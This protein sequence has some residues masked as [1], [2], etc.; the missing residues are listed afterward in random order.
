M[1]LKKQ[2]IQIARQARE[3]CPI[4]AG[5]N[6]PQ[7]NQALEKMARALIKRQ[8]SIL[9]ENKQDMD[10]AQKAGH[11]KAFLDR[12]RLTAGTLKE[13]AQGLQE[14]SR[15]PDP[16]GEVTGIWIRPN[17]LQVGRRRI[18]LGVI[19]FIYESRP[20]VTV[21]AAGLCLKSGNAVILKGGSEALGS[22]LILTRILQDV[23]VDE[24]LP[25]GAIQAI[26]TRDREATA[27]LLKLEEY[28]DLVIPRGGEGLIRTVTAQARM[29][30]LKHYKGVCHVF[31]DKGADIEMAYRIC[32]NAKVQRPGV[33]NAME[34]LLVHKDVAQ[35]FLPGMVKR[36]RKEGV[37]IRGCPQTLKIIGKGKGLLEAREEDWSEEY[38][39]LILAVRVVEG[40]TEAMAHIQQY[41]SRHT[42]AIITR[43]YDRAHEFLNSVDSSVVLVNA[44]TRFN[45]GNQ[46]GLGAE[47]G[48]STSKLHA[49]GPMGLNEL[50]TTKFIVFGQ[51]QVRG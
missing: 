14:V 18:P 39:D 24:G 26:P 2:V 32:L 30:V 34:T 35:E 41:G 8:G 37:E 36:F 25:K 22:N 46:L 47:I 5:L 28:I 10:Q 50:T 43:D 31:V 51:G 20:N 13:M 16:V 1:D 12:L 19:G 48:I 7:K 17:G 11:P 27:E 40:L 49:F 9:K 42:E 6:S 23:L 33:C 21:D 45:D 4:L 44:S 38:L 29:P 3:A 15:L